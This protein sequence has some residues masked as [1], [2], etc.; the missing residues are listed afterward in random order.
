MILVEKGR[1]KD[2]TDIERLITNYHASEGMK[3]RADRISWAVNL[4][5]RNRFPSILLVAREGNS[6][7]GI[8]LATYSPSSELG[9]V[10]MVNDF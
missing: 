7:L 10:L 5:L 4:A 8:A 1:E 3:P 6:V 2:V 9:R